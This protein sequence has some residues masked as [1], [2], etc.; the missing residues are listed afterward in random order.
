MPLIKQL[1]FS[2]KSKPNSNQIKNEFI[3][4]L[5]SSSPNNYF[6]QLFNR[7]SNINLE[8]EREKLASFGEVKFGPSVNQFFSRTNEVETWKFRI[9][10]Q[11]ENILSSFLKFLLYLQ[12]QMQN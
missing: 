6:K 12:V 4:M 8:F 3:K 9:N 2:Q 11:Y 7:A 10:K 1:T 5:D